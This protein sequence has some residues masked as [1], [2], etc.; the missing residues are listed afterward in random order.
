[1]RSSSFQFEKEFKGLLK[2]IEQNGPTERCWASFTEITPRS[3]QQ[4]MLVEAF[5]DDADERANLKR[6]ITRAEHRYRLRKTGKL[7]RN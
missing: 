4:W 2:D 3:T 6:R 5:C 7:P 1:M